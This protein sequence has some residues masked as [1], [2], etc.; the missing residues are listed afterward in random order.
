MKAII[1]VLFA[2][3]SVPALPARAGDDE[4]ARKIEKSLQSAPALKYLAKGI[5]KQY[6]VRCRAFELDSYHEED[7]VASATCID[8]DAKNK[9]EASGV[10]ITVD[11]TIGLKS[12]LMISTIQISF[13]G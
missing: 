11:G 4:L 12:P 13:A 3:V 5:E 2:L 1:A 8:R 7:F 10:V 6:G 9:S